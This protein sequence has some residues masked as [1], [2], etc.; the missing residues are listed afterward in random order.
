MAKFTKKPVT[1]EAVCYD[2]HF[3]GDL[4]EVDGVPVVAIAENTTPVWLL[5]VL[6][7]TSRFVEEVTTPL[8][9]GEALFC[10]NGILIGSTEGTMRADAGDWIIRGVNGEIYP[11][12]PDVFAKTYAPFL[13]AAAL[14]STDGDGGPA[15][16]FGDVA[17]AEVEAA[18]GRIKKDGDSQFGVSTLDVDIVVSAYRRLAQPRANAAFGDVAG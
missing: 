6:R 14:G 7:V 16:D 15:D 9:P 18:I 2:G 13:T 1:I 4:S 17:Q 8:N 3:I 5:D 10:Q 12:K 11:C